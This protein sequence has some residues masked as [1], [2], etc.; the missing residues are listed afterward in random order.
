M[1]LTIT[2]NF[3]S[4][5]YQTHPKNGSALPCSFMKKWNF[6]DCVGAINFYK[7]HVLIHLPPLRTQDHNNYFNY[8]HTFS[9]VL[10]A[11][12]DADYKFTYV[13]VGCNGR[14]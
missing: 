11:V 3:L 1:H 5:R 4:C 9:I 12:V 7:K 13:D 10:L 8:K 2:I 6:P 14:T